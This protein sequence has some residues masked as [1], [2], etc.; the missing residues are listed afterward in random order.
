MPVFCHKCGEELPSGS[1][2]SPFCPH[3]GSPQLYL[4][5]ENQSVETGGEPGVDAA[6]APTTGKLPPPRPRQV[7]WKTAIRCVAAV[8]GVG[9][10]LSLGSMRVAVLSPVSFVW[11]LSASMITM[12]LYQNRRPKAWMDVRVGARIGVV[13]GICLAVGLGAA[14]ASWGVIARFGLHSMGSFDQQMTDQMLQVQ[15]AIQQKAVQQATPV[16]AEMMGLIASPEFRAGIMLATFAMVSVFLLA[17]S[18][19]GGAFAGLLRMRRSP[20]V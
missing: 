4:S 1:G 11:I 3:C 10:L 16:P 5:L 20:A 9:A 14:M 19:L 2:E 8:A 15:K 18:T 6:G 13:V 12:A 7:D 17:L